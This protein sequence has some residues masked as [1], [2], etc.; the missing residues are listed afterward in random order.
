MGTPTATRRRGRRSGLAKQV[1]SRS[2]SNGK[3][4]TENQQLQA[5]HDS[6]TAIGDQEDGDPSAAETER[7]LHHLRD[8]STFA[9]LLPAQD[10]VPIDPSLVDSALSNRNDHQ[11]SSAAN[12]AV[13]VDNAAGGPLVGT[14]TGEDGPIGE[15]SAEGV[16]SRYKKGPPGSCDICGRIET[17]VW[18]KL[19]LG[20]IELKVC[21]GEWGDTPGTCPDVR[22][23][24]MSPVSGD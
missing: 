5:R 1:M 21:N 11:G 23:T 8:T 20:D 10:D 2:L 7:L 24:M 14:L 17:S 16:L 9:D 19:T 12:G 18:R 13:V 3:D 4:Q 22:A 6:P 15:I